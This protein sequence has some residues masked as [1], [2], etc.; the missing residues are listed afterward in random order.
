MME[1]LF[2]L[3]GL[4]VMGV[5]F[6]GSSDDDP[7]VETPSGGGGGSG[8]GADRLIGDD[9]D[10][11]L[12]GLWG[13]DSIAGRAGD[14][15]L[16]GGWGNDLLI[17][18]TGNDALAGNGD[19]DIL[20]GGPGADTLDGGWGN[21]IIIG[22]DNAEALFNPLTGGSLD[23]LQALSPAQLEA[24]IADLRADAGPSPDA[25]TQDRLDMSIT[26]IRAMADPTLSAEILANGEAGSDV[27]IGNEGDDILIGD[28]GDTMTGGAG[29]DTF[30]VFYQPGPDHELLTI[31]DFNHESEQLELLIPESL[32]GQPHNAVAIAPD[33]TH[34]LLNG[35]VV[36]ELA[37]VAMEDY[38]TA[39]RADRVVFATY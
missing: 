24:L 14:D 3:L 1:L 10:D 28:A 25:L 13:N 15:I 26:M 32:V 34:V 2:M 7:E 17:G 36:L 31:S 11:T 33:T 22:V 6:G 4:G 29:N 8:G 9:S 30:T 39:L 12:N 38:I 18:G 27:L 37:G 20:F 23:Q 19:S 21:D 35:V 5:A 16:T